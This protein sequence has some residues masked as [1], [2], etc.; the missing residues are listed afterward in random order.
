[1]A[2]LAHSSGDEALDAAA[3]SMM[4]EAAP[5]TLIPEP[6]RDRSF[7]VSLPVIFDASGD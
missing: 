4:R 1:V 3:L 7:S 2:R 5:R 6:L